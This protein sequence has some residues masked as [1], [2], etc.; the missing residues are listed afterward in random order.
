MWLIQKLTVIR[1]LKN[2]IS[3]PD[4]NTLCNEI[5][6]ND[7]SDSGADVA[8]QLIKMYDGDFKTHMYNIYLQHSELK[9][10]KQNLNENQT[11]F[12]IDFSK[13]YENKQKNEIPSTYFGH[14]SFTL[15]TAACY[16][17]SP[18][19]NAKYDPDFNFYVISTV[20]VS[21]EINHE[22]NIA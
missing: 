17:K 8:E 22:R 19:P 15:Y 16:F 11:I 12:S 2:L 20:I 6:S 4:L 21:N 7:I 5:Y 1:A 3:S 13:N 9:F 10:L 18:F 14:E